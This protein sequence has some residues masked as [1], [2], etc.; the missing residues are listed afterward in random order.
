MIRKAPDFRAVR[1][2]AAAGAGV[3]APDAGVR[4]VVPAHDIARGEIIADTDLTYATVPGNA[5]MAG[6]V[7]SL[8]APRRH[9]SAPRCC[10]PAKLSA[11]TMCAS[12]IVVTKGQTVTM[13]FDAPAWS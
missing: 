12:P 7:T 1:A 4:M 10:A 13:T 8:D 5:M 11:P 9:G 2:S 3:A 6:I